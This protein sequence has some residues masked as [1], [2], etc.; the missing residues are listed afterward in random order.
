MSLTQKE[1]VLYL[2]VEEV[3]HYMWDPIG[4]AGVPQARDEYES[5]A[6]KVFDLVRGTTDGKDVAAYLSW[7]STDL[8]GQA[9]DPDGDSA[10]VEALL[11]WR[12]YL[13]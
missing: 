2:R 12:E 1:R 11:S 10:V 8:M 13:R 6:P 5:Y 9:P 4:I 3:L 7:V